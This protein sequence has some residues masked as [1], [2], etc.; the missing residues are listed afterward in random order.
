MYNNR[1]LYPFKETLFPK[2]FIFCSKVVI[3]FEITTFCF[4]TIMVLMV[5]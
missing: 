2:R 3:C 1:V 5:L 4:L